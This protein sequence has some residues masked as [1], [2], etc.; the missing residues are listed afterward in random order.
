MLT[1]LQNYIETDESTKSPSVIPQG[2]S[3]G[4]LVC[5]GLVVGM[6]SW[7]VGCGRR[8]LPGVYTSVPYWREWITSYLKLTMTQPL[9]PVKSLTHSQPPLSTQP[10]P[11]VHYLTPAHPRQSDNPLPT[12]NMIPFQP[13]LSYQTI[14]PV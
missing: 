14:P 12:T 6:V 5:G 9:P 8:G 7:G 11:P 1:E 2:D 4:P 13:S 3:G 10:L